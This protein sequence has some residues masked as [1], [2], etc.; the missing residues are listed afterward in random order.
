MEEDICIHIMSVMLTNLELG[1]TKVN[2]QIGGCAHGHFAEAKLLFKLHKAKTHV[3]NG[4][5]QTFCKVGL[6]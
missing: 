1:L 2:R 5:R 4:L 6:E 3:Q